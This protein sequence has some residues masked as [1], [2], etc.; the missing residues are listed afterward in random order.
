MKSWR[1]ELGL[2]LFYFDPFHFSSITDTQAIRLVRFLVISFPHDEEVQTIY[3]PIMFTAIT[4]LVDVR[5]PYS[6]P[7]AL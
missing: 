6:V 5:L 7:E 2:R 3:F 1:V 4:A